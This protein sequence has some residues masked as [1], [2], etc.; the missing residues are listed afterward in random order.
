[1]GMFVRLH[2]KELNHKIEITGFLL[3]VGSRCRTK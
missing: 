2:G 3:E 1:M